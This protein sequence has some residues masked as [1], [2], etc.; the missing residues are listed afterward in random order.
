MGKHPEI[1]A[2]VDAL[3]IYPGQAL[4]VWLNAYD[5]CGEKREAVQVELRV[6][7]GEYGRREIFIS[8]KVGTVAVHHDFNDWEPM[9]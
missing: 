5:K 4:T 3:N 9:K 2:E 6:K 1:H 8:D 7:P